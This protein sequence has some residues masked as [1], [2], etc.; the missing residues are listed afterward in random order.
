MFPGKKDS[1]LLRA[2]SFLAISV[3]SFYTISK[4]KELQEMFYEE[5]KIRQGNWLLILYGILSMGL[6][7]LSMF[8]GFTSNNR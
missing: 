6:L 2:V 3:F 5:T 4:E 8:Y 1:F 7:V